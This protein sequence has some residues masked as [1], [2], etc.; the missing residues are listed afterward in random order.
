MPGNPDA[1]YDAALRRS[2]TARRIE[3]DRAHELA[4][5]VHLIAEDPIRRGT[6][7]RLSPSMAEALEA[8]RL[9]WAAENA[10]EAV[11]KAAYAA[12]AE[13]N[14]GLFPPA[15][16]SCPRCHGSGEVTEFRGDDAV[17]GLCPCLKGGATHAR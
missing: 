5:L 12:R 15:A 10:A 3:A 13:A 8:W 9:A 2:D 16:K 6:L 14:P 11:R 4:H 1:A 17:L 7:M